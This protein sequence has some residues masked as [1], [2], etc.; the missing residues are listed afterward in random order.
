MEETSKAQVEVGAPVEA[1]TPVKVE[2]PVEVVAPVEAEIPVKVEAP[3]EA[4]APVEVGAQVETEEES[5][6]EVDESQEY[7]AGLREKSMAREKKENEIFSTPKVDSEV[8]PSNEGEP[9]NIDDS[10]WDFDFNP[11][12]P[13]TEEVLFRE[14]MK[15][16]ISDLGPLKFMWWDLIKPFESYKGIITFEEY[17]VII[18]KL[19]E[20]ITFDMFID[21][22]YKI[23]GSEFATLLN[24]LKKAKFPLSF[25]EKKKIM[26]YIDIL[27]ARGFY[28]SS[29]LTCLIDGS[30]EK[31]KIDDETDDNNRILQIGLKHFFSFGPPPPDKNKEYSIV[32]RQDPKIEGLDASLSPEELSD[33]LNLHLGPSPAETRF[34]VCMF[35][36]SPLIRHVLCLAYLKHETCE[37]WEEILFELDFTIIKYNYKKLEFDFIDRLKSLIHKLKTHDSA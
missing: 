1:E 18:E 23:I 37:M 22:I 2:A 12:P 31:I 13:I 21:F 9:S 14:L 24:D 17:N 35:D 26:K 25:D 4:G 27:H 34:H 33:V 11:P 3:V 6:E 32:I 19:Y 5:E 8:E 16:A 30:F 15:V 10:L 20:K 28:L 36:M 29:F 7:Y